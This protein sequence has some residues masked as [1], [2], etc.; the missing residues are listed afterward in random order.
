[1]K[2][3]TLRALPAILLAV[4]SSAATATGLQS[5]EQD[6]A[7]LG[8]AHA[9]SAAI[10][11]TAAGQFYNPAG[12]SRLDGVQVSAGITGV[13]SRV[14]FDNGGS[15]GASL[16]VGDGG[17]AGRWLATANA[18][19]GWRLNPDLTIGFGITSPFGLDLEYEHDNWLGR[20]HAQRAEL[21][22]RNYNPSIAYRVSE[23]VAVGFGLNYQTIDLDFANA[24]SRLKGDDGSWGWNAGALFTLSPAMR[25][26]ISYRSAIEHDLEGSANGQA[27]RARIEMP[28]TAILS[29]WQQVSDRWEA[30]GDLSYT[31]WDRLKNLNFVNRNTG[32]LLA[33]EPFA[34]GNSWRLAWGA[35]YLLSDA[36]K[37][38]FGIAYE[39]S[40]SGS[41]A[42]N[43][44]APDSDALRLSLGGQ[45][46]LGSGRLDAG[47]SYHLAKD[48]K[49]AQNRVVGGLSNTLRGEYETGTHTLGIQ[50]SA[51][52]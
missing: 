41:P 49:I 7:G 17:D 35:A 33:S 3:M 47:Y 4:F 44:W 23:R 20:V 48:A 45:W 9:G 24:A 19:L 21:R 26:G 50:Y 10:A 25:V 11:D 37:L 16:G 12:L 38:K 51:A 14:E 43:A 5:W 28:D 22:T 36:V 31:R 2:T 42:R 34:Y 27:A 8:T 30:M 52:F 40:P 46:R 32:A 29:V 18:S 6:A 1:M 39:R 15:T 13:R